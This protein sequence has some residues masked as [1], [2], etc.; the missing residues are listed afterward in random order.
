MYDEAFTPLRNNFLA[1]LKDEFELIE[2]KLNKPKFEPNANLSDL[3][4]GGIDVWLEKP[5]YL[6]RMIDQCQP[7]EYFVYSDID[8]VFFKPMLPKL[9]Q[10]L[11]D[12]DVVFLREIPEGLVPWQG[13]DVAGNCNFGFCIIKACERSKQFFKHVLA[14]IEQTRLMDQTVVNKILFGTPHYNLNWGV[15]P[16]EFTTT[17]FINSNQ[18]NHESI[19]FHA[20]CCV[21]QQ[22][23]L[24]LLAHAQSI[25]TKSV[26]TCA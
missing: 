14:T 15:L 23:K 5:K 16:I 12:K 19:M 9:N 4:G 8:I 11:I 13:G 20:I 21:D 10:I 25:V 17:S 24:G 6:L 18:L 2:L 3:Y 22:E 7:D 26:E 1:N